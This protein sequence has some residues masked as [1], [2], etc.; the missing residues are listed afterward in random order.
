MMDR[1]PSRKT[2]GP[3][4]YDPD[5]HDQGEWFREQISDAEWNDYEWVRVETFGKPAKY[6]RG[7]KLT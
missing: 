5:E 2:H 3:T 1:P 4:S 7:P 6:L